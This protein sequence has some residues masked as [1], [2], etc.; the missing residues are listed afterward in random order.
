MG[1]TLWS[2]IK[3]GLLCANALAV[4][5]EPRF[6]TQC[7]SQSRVRCLCTRRA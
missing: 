7:E 2:L 4:L 3:V 1:L 6:L 5:N